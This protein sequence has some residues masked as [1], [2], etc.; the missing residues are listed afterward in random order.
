MTAPKR[1]RWNCPH[2]RHPAVL[3][4]SRPALDSIVRYCLPCSFITG[5]LEKRIAPTLESKRAAAAVTSAAKAKAK[6]AR[7]ARARERKKQAETERYTVEGVDLREDFKRLIKL[8]AFGGK[9]GRL[10]RSPPEFVISRRT[11]HPARRLGY[12][13]PW[14]NR[15]TVATYPGQS[16]AGVRETLVHELTHIVVGQRDGAWHGPLFHKTLRAAFSEA[17][18]VTPRMLHDEE[19][20]YEEGLASALRRHSTSAEP[21]KRRSGE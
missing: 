9:T 14:R 18:K 21:Q 16:L 3:G 5:R 11:Q 17:Y 7:E 12:A 6:R 10:F 15:I 2:D 1:I 19:G 4:P 20:Y 13:E 8:R